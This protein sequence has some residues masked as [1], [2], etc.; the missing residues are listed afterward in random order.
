MQPSWTGTWPHGNG[1]TK[2]PP[3]RSQ[4][5]ITRCGGLCSAR[6]GQGYDRQLATGL[7]T[8]YRLPVYRPFFCLPLVLTRHAMR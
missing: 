1:R 7:R 8:K 6:C 3:E 5:A 2:K 4:A